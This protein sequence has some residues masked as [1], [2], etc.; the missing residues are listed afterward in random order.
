MKTMLRCSGAVVAIALL[1]GPGL[2]GD[3]A[4]DVS[5]ELKKMQGTWT[6]TTGDGG[7]GRWVFE[8]GKLT[9]TLPNRKY[10][11]EVKVDEK[12]KPYPTMD[13]KVT[14]GPEDAK[15]MNVLGIYKLDG[16]TLV[17]CIGGDG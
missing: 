8:G 5:G 10:V 14:D 4:K 7:E 6:S 15:G 2:L 16:D 11:T 13:F 12:A 17:I 3:E 1:A 9:V